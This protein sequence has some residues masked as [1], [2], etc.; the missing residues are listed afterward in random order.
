MEKSWVFLGVIKSV[1]LCDIDAVM[2][3]RSKDALG[4]NIDRFDVVTSKHS[5]K[6]I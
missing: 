5:T 3:L 4:R 6:Q 1:K 2:K